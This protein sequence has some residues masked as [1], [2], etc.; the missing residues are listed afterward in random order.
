MLEHGRNI[1][2]RKPLGRNLV[3]EVL[4][5]SKAR[6]FQANQD[7][8][9]HYARHETRAKQRSARAVDTSR[10]I[11]AEEDFRDKVPGLKCEGDWIP[12][13]TSLHVVKNLGAPLVKVHDG[14]RHKTTK[15]K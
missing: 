5:P 1:V 9:Q 4:N 7:R 11:W 3:Q 10:D 6:H 14:I 15:L 13:E 2:K 8:Q 12:H